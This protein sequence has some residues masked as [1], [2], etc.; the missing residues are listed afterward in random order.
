MFTGKRRTALR[1][2]GSRLPLKNLAKVEPLLLLQMVIDLSQ[3]LHGT[4]AQPEAVARALVRDGQQRLRALRLAAPHVNLSLGR[5]LLWISSKDPSDDCLVEEDGAF[6]AA[7][8]MCLGLVLQWL[9]R[10]DAPLRPQARPLPPRCSCFS[11][12]RFSFRPFPSHLLF[13]TRS[14][15]IA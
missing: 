7:L 14:C 1:S 4:V 2:L 13:R 3:V 8:E 10:G 11:E 12:G 15:P 9:S 5:I 6:E